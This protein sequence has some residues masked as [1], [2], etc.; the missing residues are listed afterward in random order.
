MATTTAMTHCA[1]C[2]KGGDGLKACTACKLVKY[3][4]V[5]CQKA[6]RP[7]HK[8]ECRKRAAEL[9]DEAL[10]AVPPPREECPICFLPLPWAVSQ[11]QYQ[12]CCGKKLCFGCGFAA[13]IEHG[14]HLCPFCRSP[15][16]P[17]W[18]ATI[19]KVKARADTNDANATLELG[20]Y[21]KEARGGLKRDLKRAV[22]LWLRAGKL[23]KASGYCEVGN[24]Y[25]LGKGVEKDID[26][27]EHY[28]ELAAM[29]GDSEARHNLGVM[30]ADEKGNHDRAIKHFMLAAGLGNTGSLDIIQEYYLNKK[31]QLVTKDEFEK[32]L[33]AHYEAINEMKSE[34][35]DKAVALK[36]FVSFE[37]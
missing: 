6:H 24:C 32:A 21:Y 9:H 31:Q 10:F 2:G 19:K 26:K 36:P 8:R 13:R 11:S 28:W 1:S 20:Y 29:R 16:L 23:G 5:A 4:G 12:A 37:T 14:Q 25:L 3:C 7:R 35:R 27:A 18:D 22:E 30:E 17:N 33:R 34:Q 15:T